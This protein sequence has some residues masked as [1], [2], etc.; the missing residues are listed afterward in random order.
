MSS[1]RDASSMKCIMVFSSSF[2]QATSNHHPRHRETII[3]N[4]ILKYWVSI[5]RVTQFIL[6]DGDG[7]CDNCSLFCGV[8]ELLGTKI[9]TMTTCSPWS[10]GIIKRPKAVIENMNLKIT[11]D[12]NCSVGS[13]LELS[14][15]CQKFPCQ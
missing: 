8:T 1:T 15:Q 3:A 4:A 6:S 9:H 10:N 5:F 12:T 2:S 14:N 7:K 13:A 11:Q